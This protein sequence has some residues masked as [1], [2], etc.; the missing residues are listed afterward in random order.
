VKESPPPPE[1]A[2]GD[3]AI[4]ARLVED[5]L[6]G[7]HRSHPAEDNVRKAGLLASGDPDSTFGMSD[8]A[9]ATTDEALAAVSAVTGAREPGEAYIDPRATIAGAREAAARLGAACRA[10]ARIMVATGHPTGLLYHHVRLVGAITG[11]GGRVI[12]PLD[13]EVLFRENGGVRRI[14][15][16]GGVG[17]LSDGGNLLHTHSPAAMER[18]LADGAPPALVVA[19][20]GFA[21]AAIARGIPTIAVMDTNDPALA[22]ARARGRDVALIP[23]DDNRRPDAYD[24]IAELFEQELV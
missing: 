17:V 10:G 2:P 23:M 20:H 1:D 18:V 24:V 9:T 13:E 22:V 12:R 16:V 11:A 7:P 21:G 3:S 4:V 15:Y 19:D 8:V 6:A 14:K 5:G